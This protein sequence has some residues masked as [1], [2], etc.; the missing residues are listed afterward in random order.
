LTPTSKYRYLLVLKVLIVP[1]L[2]VFY[3]RNA[4]TGLAMYQ[5]IPVWVAA[6]EYARLV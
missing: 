3:C 5:T 4:D 1:L 6:F 2:Y